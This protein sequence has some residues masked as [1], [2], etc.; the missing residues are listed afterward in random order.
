M[1]RLIYL[2]VLLLALLA[3]TS[4]RDSDSAKSDPVVMPSGWP[5]A[6][7][8]PPVGSQRTT[9]FGLQE[10]LSNDG[11]YTIQGAKGAGDFEGELWAVAFESELG[12]PEI[13]AYTERALK[14]RNFSALENPLQG[15]PSIDWP[16]FQYLSPDGRQL[17]VLARSAERSGKDGA[18]NVCIIKVSLL[19][20]IYSGSDYRRAL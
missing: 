2:S 13:V 12:W 9:L 3:L 8:R 14:K 19:D 10:S 15:T 20:E 5:I 11:G 1:S 6:E 16:A 18:A 7:V 17:V 4:C